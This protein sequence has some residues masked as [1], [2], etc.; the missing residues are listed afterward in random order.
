MIAPPPLVNFQSLEKYLDALDPETREAHGGTIE[1]LH[2]AGLPPVVSTRALATLFGYRSQFIG[3]MVSRPHRYYRTFTIR[4][5]KKQRRIEAPRVALKVIQ[6]WF[7]HY[8]AR[9]IAMPDEVV[10][11]VPSRSI[12]HGATKHCGAKWL[13]S[14]DLKDFFQSTS[15]ELVVQALE[16]LGYPKHG[17]RLIADLTT[18]N[19]N[20]AQGSPASPVLS[21]LAFQPVD[22]ALIAMSKE[23]GVTYTRYADDI[24]VS[25]AGEVPHAL[26]AAVQQ[27]V[28]VGNW[29]L[30]EE[31]TEFVQ[32]PCRLKVYGLLVNGDKPRLTKGYRRRIRAIRHL[33]ASNMIPEDRAAQAAGH[34]SYAKS[35]ENF[36]PPKN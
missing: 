21:N 33:I 10:G 29:K 26:H 14:T 24:V 13:F 34:I 17:A 35:V 6:K 23:L 9:A 1:A 4:K 19:R 15:S 28:E 16:D 5:G 11:F 18:L 7:G 8:L 36:E 2:H 20:L 25:G 22:N 27:I 31:K 12:M 3:A 32:A 30:S